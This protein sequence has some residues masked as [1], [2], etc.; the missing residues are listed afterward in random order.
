[1]SNWFRTYGFA[2]ILE[3]FLIGALPCDASDVALLQMLGVTRIVNLV[4]DEE[5]EPGARESVVAALAEAG[6]AERRIGLTDFG[7]LPAEPLQEAVEAVRES[8]A[9][10]EVVYLHCRAG[11]QRSAAIAAGIVALERD[12]PLEDALEWVTQ[13]KPSANPLEHQREDLLAW[14]LGR[15]ASDGLAAPEPPDADRP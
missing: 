7:R 15:S 13:A 12:L 8:L 2:E 3:G 1:M 4:E 10:G 6:M 9:E 11:W 5:Y 14:W